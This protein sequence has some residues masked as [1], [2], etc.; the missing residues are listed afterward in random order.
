MPTHNHQND[1]V[2]DKNTT[3]LS[4]NTRHVDCVSSTW[5]K[6]CRACCTRF[7]PFGRRAAAAARDCDAE[8]A[9]CWEFL[10]DL[11]TCIQNDESCE[12][13]VAKLESHVLKLKGQ[14]VTACSP[15]AVHRRTTTARHDV[16]QVS[17]TSADT[18]VNDENDDNESF[19]NNESHS[20]HSKQQQQQHDDDKLIQNWNKRCNDCK[21]NYNNKHKILLWNE[22]VTRLE[23]SIS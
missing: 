11:T 22:W 10:Q 16:N 14:Q 20:C 13:M 3:L 23:L 5:T 6:K 1:L 18:T 15:T 12:Y 17:F 21:M 8:N 4:M 7:S 9:V 2:N 19:T